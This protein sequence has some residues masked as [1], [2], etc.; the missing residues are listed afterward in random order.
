MPNNEQ[1]EIAVVVQP[2]VGVDPRAMVVIL[3]DTRVEWQESPCFQ[4]SNGKRCLV[5]GL[6]QIN[7]TVVTAQKGAVSAGDELGSPKGG[8]S[9]REEVYNQ[10]MP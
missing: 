1:H 3:G 2:H 5:F 7:S 10:T 9:G 8:G 4:E 6:K